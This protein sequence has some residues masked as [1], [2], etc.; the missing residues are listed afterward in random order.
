MV[1]QCW[2]GPANEA[3]LDEGQ[4]L[5]EEFV[6]GGAAVGDPEELSEALGDEAILDEQVREEGARECER[7]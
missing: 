7:E 6:A 3:A 1:I 4:A 5:V 2:A